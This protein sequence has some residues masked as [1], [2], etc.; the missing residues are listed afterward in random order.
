MTE[1]RYTATFEPAEEGGYIVTV[2]ALPG[3]VTYGSNLD[4]A[5][6][7]A[8]DAI[9]CH[10]EALRKKGLPIPEDKPPYKIPIVS[11]LAV[12]I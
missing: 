3:L 7:M 1:Y 5:E 2:E 8:I 12:A 4:E 11:R 10:I 6:A 9:I